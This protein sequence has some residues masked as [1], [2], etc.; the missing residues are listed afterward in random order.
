[1]PIDEVVSADISGNGNAYVLTG[2]TIDGT[3][4]LRVDMASGAVIQ[5][6]SFGG[7]DVAVDDAHDAVWI[8]GSDIKKLNRNLQL[9]NDPIDPIEWSAVSVDFASDG[10]A[11]VAERDYTVDQGRL[12]RVNPD[13]SLGLTVPLPSSPYSVRVNRSE[14]TVWVAMSDGLRKY[15]S[16][17]NELLAMTGLAGWSV[18]VNQ[19][20]GSV[21]LAARDGTL[22]RFSSGGSI[23]LV[24]P[25]APGAPT[26]G[27][28]IAL[29]VP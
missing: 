11:W 27:A 12:L 4:I 15:D 2:T 22:T 19:F 14:G 26:R 6:A 7:I 17:G 25:R 29:R 24:R 8:V 21:W 1:L 9:Q 10:S 28:W 23:L 5:T 3:S 20:D 16:N 13:G 18:A